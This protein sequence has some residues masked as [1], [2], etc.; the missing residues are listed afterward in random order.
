MLVSHSF[1]TG[2][3]RSR[4]LHN[5]VHQQHHQEKLENVWCILTAKAGILIISSFYSYHLHINSQVSNNFQ[6][7]QMTCPWKRCSGWLHA[8]M[9]SSANLSYWWMRTTWQLVNIPFLDWTIHQTMTTHLTNLATTFVSLYYCSLYH[10]ST[11]PGNS[12]SS[13][14]K[15][16]QQSLTIID[17]Q[18]TVSQST[19]IHDSTIIRHH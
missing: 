4:V 5:F 6:N 12:C 9:L 10:P 3:Q 15:H 19:I 14:F 7:E 16:H 1:T 17:Q 11:V 13:I 2:C 8:C 18:F